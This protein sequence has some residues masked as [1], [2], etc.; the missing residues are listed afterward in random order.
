MSPF[1]NKTNS[2]L[3]QKHLIS[4]ATIESLEGNLDTSNHRLLRLSDP[5]TRIVVLL[6]GLLRTLG[7]T[8]LTLEV[9]LLLLIEV[10]ET[11][12]ISPLGIGIN[13]HLDDSTLDSGGDLLRE[14]TATTVE[15]EEDGVLSRKRV[16]LDDVV[17]SVLENFRSKLDITRS[18]D[19]VDVTEGGG[20]AESGGDAA[21]LFPYLADLLGLRVEGGVVDASVIDTIFLTTGAA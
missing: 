6:V 3:I 10:S 12:P 19:T 1:N 4:V 21:E 20:D 16:L 17:L 2:K 18:V 9:V 14:G 8:D 13:V 7:I 11:S 5:D 15:D